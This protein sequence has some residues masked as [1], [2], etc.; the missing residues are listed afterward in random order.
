MIANSLTALSRLAVSNIL[1]M[2]IHLMDNVRSLV[3]ADSF[4]LSLMIEYFLELMCSSVMGIT[5]VK[6]A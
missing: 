6:E 1:D 4:L 5:I 2:L 3:N